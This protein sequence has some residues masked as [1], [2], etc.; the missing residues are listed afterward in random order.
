MVYSIELAAYI[1]RHGMD[2]Q[3]FLDGF[4]IQ[5]EP[6]QTRKQ[7]I[8]ARQGGYRQRKDLSNDELA[9]VVDMYRRGA[10]LKHIAGKFNIRVETVNKILDSADIARRRKP[11]R[12]VDKTR[13]VEMLQAGAPAAKV[14][15]VLECAEHTILEYRRELRDTG[16]L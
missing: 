13:A 1:S 3:A 16:R 7:T 14:A 9:T 10:K 8:H 6:E 12:R 11:T 15:E 4:P 2:R 5:K